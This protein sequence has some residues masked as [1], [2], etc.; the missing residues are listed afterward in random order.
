MVEIPPALRDKQFFVFTTAETFRDASEVISAAMHNGK[1]HLG[2]AYAVMGALSLEIY[3]KCLLLIECGQHP[4][5]HNIK[6]L[7]MQL[8]SRTRGP[9]RKRHNEL[10]I[11]DPVFINV[12]ERLNVATD[13]DSLL[14]RGQNS[15]E[16]MR[17]PYDFALEDDTAF[18]FHILRE[19]IRLRILDLRPQWVTK[20]GPTSQAR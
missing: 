15:F 2:W 3:L 6:K 13:L 19:V 20:D 1:T 12:R 10:A 9:L 14:E 8:P 18:G 5:S 11:N 7:F 4:A 17:Y 16:I